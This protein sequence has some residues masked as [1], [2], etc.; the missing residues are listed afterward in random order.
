MAGRPVYFTPNP[1]L[2]CLINGLDMLTQTWLEI[3]L[4]QP[5]PVNFRVGFRSGF[6]SGQKLPPL[7]HTHSLTNRSSHLHKLVDEPTNFSLFFIT[8]ASVRVW[9]LMKHA[10]LAL[11]P[12]LVTKM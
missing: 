10:W 2:T 12:H 5:E 6:V 7:P 11:L 4:A 1:S 8:N 3:Y 9:V